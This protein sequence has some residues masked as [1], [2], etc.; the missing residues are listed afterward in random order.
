MTEEQ[1]AIAKRA[2]ACKGWQW[3]PGMVA[4]HP[5]CTT[6][7]VLFGRGYTFLGAYR[8]EMKAKNPSLWQG[9]SGQV[10]HGQYGYAGFEHCTP[11][12]DIT[13]PATLGCMLA[14]VRDAYVDHRIVAR[15]DPEEEVWY[16][17]TQ[18][19]ASWAGNEAEALVAALEAAP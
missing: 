10:Q 7:R 13:D 16:V 18:Y 14:L 19:G 9:W 3:M 12:P 5:D 4:I 2:V 6:S 17:I 11:H 1:I 8:R 15:P